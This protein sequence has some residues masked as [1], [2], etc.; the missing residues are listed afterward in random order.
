MQIPGRHG[1]MTSSQLESVILRNSDFLAVVRAGEGE[2]RAGLY[3]AVS[4]EYIH[5]IQGGV[6]PEYSRHNK[7]EYDCSCTTGGLCR[8][9]MHGTQL[10]LGWRN[11]L[12]ALLI[13]RKVRPT[14]EI[15]RM[16]G[17]HETLQAYDYGYICAPQTDPSPAW[18]YSGVTT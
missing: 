5:P 11:I 1:S 2:G 15:R 3:E 6:L 18:I 13:K 16:L 17:S 12:F 14:P 9:S 7:L 10:V 8:S 4:G